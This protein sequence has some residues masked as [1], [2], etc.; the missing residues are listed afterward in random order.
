MTKQKRNFQFSLRWM[1]LAMFL[2]SAST[3][4][5]LKF[6]RVEIPVPAEL[7]VDYS[8][9]FAFVYETR[10]P[11]VAASVRE[12]HA[13]NE[14]KA[15]IYRD[16]TPEE[17]HQILAK[18]SQRNREKWK[19]QLSPEKVE[20]YDALKIARSGDSTGFIKLVKRHSSG[21]KE[22]QEKLFQYIHNFP[23]KMVIE[24]DE[25]VK[26]IKNKIKEDGFPAA[27]QEAEILHESGVDSQPLIEYYKWEIENR[28]SISQMGD[29]L[30]RLLNIA[31]YEENFRLALEIFED[32]ENNSNRGWF[33]CDELIEK[34][35]GF[36][37]FEKAADG[38]LK[39][40]LLE[41]AIR[42]AEEDRKNARYEDRY[43][44]ALSKVD[45]PEVVSYF[46]ET[47]SRP[48]YK[49]RRNW[50]LSVLEQFGEE[51]EANLALDAILAKEVFPD[52]ILS[53]FH[54][55]DGSK[56]VFLELAKR[57]KKH[58]SYPML[59]E[60]YMLAK[61][62]DQKKI[63]NSILEGTIEDMFDENSPYF[64]RYSII[65]WLDTLGYD[66]VDELR[67][68][69]PVVNDVWREYQKPAQDFVD[70]VN[71]NLEPLKHVKIANVNG[72]HEGHPYWYRIQAMEESG[73]VVY[74]DPQDFQFESQ[75]FVK[76]TSAC[77]EEFQIEAHDSVDSHIRL[78]IN[79]VTYSFAFDDS[80][81]WFDVVACCEL[82]NTILKRQK[83]E[84][85]FFVFSEPYGNSYMLHALFAKPKL[86]KELAEKYG[87]SFIK[88]CEVYWK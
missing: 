56:A 75:F 73:R 36:E 23:P 63:A 12:N 28:R 41:T 27:R 47:A 13:A 78:L 35:L 87:D 6:R 74:L 67:K 15:K 5:Y 14:E 1:L 55:R 21:S 53:H 86:A 38:E 88:G 57:L 25:L 66:R 46:R 20:Y 81:A 19:A 22:D 77:G 40:Q 45:T 10:N 37:E 69:V 68:R 9:R 61:E 50:A 7:H 84:K 65:D 3:V 71:Q 51:G 76:I 4:L 34:L 17:Q 48:R 70:W 24:N 58:K 72:G 83:I 43:F 29:A 26:L 33:T 39:E 30:K 49:S 11:F 42:Y 52:D 80:E 64:K 82:L 8:P 85:R 79:G 54:Y 59:S 44:E 18:E 31:P 32:R 62:D 60:M 2:I 16:A